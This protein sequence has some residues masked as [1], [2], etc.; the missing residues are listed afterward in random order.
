MEKH[1]FAGALIR[2]LRLEKNWSQETLCKD[3]CAVSYLS[4]IEQGRV[5]PN[6][7]LLTDI[8]SKLGINWCSDLRGK[9]RALCEALY[10]SIFSGNTKAQL[11]N[12][13]ALRSNWDHQSIGP[14]Y[15]DF[16]TLMAYCAHDSSSI[17][18]QMYPLMDDRQ[19]CL[20][21]VLRDAPEDA[22][23]RYPCAF[24]AMAIGISRYSSG[25]YTSALDYLQRAYD[26][27]C[28]QG[29]VHLMMTSK[30]YIAN[31]YSDL[32]D[33]IAM[34]KHAQVAERLARILNDTEMV[35]SIHYNIACTQMECN[36]YVDSYH[37]FAAVQDP[38]VLEL[39]KLAI[40]CEKLGLQ[41]EAICA[42]DAAEKVACGVEANMCRLVRYRL[43]NPG[44]LNDPGYGKL[45]M[46]TFD[47]IRKERPVG[48]A[49]FHLPWIEEWCKANRQYR[50]VY[51]VL[52]DFS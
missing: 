9:R 13:G 10:D 47:E 16:I 42:L 25:D 34:E 26:L 48:Y 46:N 51:E 8:F 23:R 22:W 31:C 6:N 45:L 21:H 52:K 3:I 38:S 37:Y 35:Q 1:R 41:G 24:S 49:R 5:Y 39:H 14:E 28:Q 17:P 7:T 43:D 50:L 15:L 40:C 29:Y 32:Q 30:I 20:I 18:Q 4:K 33:L 36:N 12:E 27:A 44:Y 19:A 11:Q 2:M